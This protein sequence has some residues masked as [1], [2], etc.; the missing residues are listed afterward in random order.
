MSTGVKLLLG[1]PISYVE[2]LVQVLAIAVPILLPAISPG[3]TEDDDKI[4]VY[5]LLWKTQMGLALTIVSIWRRTQWIEEKSSCHSAFQV[6]KEIW[7]V[8]RG[9]KDLLGRLKY[10]N[11]L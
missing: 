8:G 5:L 1:K 6:N 11:K 4:L 9:D 7:G 10:H 2:G 3:Q